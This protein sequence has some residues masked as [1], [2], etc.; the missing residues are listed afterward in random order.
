MNRHPANPRASGARARAHRVLP[1]RAARAFTLV[2]IL[3]ALS[4]GVLVSMAAFTLS[5]NATNFFQQ[6]ARVSTA[7]LSL[8]LGLNRIASDLARASFLSTPNAQADPMVCRDGSWSNAPG[9]QR[10]AGVFIRSGQGNAQSAANGFA[11]QQLIIGGSLDASEVF[12]VQCVLSGTGTAPALQLQTPQFDGAMARV[13]AAA[14]G[15][16]NLSAALN[17]IF[18]PGRFLQILD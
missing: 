18:V 9:L 5:K 3:V 4:A 15:L 7:Q 2:E 6:E 10:L 11:P 13:M 16:P 8:T 12:T 17:N 1:R 14:G